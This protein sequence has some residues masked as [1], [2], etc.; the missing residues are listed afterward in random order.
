MTDTPRVPRGPCRRRIAV[1]LA[2]AA[3]AAAGALLPSQALAA[4][5]T[6]PQAGPATSVTAPASGH[7]GQRDRD[8][9]H[10][11]D[12]YRVR[13][14]H[15]TQHGHHQSWGRWH[16]HTYWYGYGS[17]HGNGHGNG[18]GHGHGYSNWFGQFGGRAHGI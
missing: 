4:P 18:H 2:S 12:G 10:G 16:C 8:R 15:W 14:C 9:D 7:D 5:V 1:L 6:A 11:G 13:Y 17:D 3:L